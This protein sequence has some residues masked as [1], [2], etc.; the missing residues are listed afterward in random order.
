MQKFMRQISLLCRE[1]SSPSLGG[2]HYAE[3]SATSCLGVF[4]KFG[5]RS[6]AE[7]LQ[8]FPPQVLEVKLCSFFVGSLGGQSPP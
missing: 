5:G 1:P 4:P 7:F 6:Y 3:I 8:T 2:R